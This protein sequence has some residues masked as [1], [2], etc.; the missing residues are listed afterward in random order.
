[1]RGIQSP[2]Y[3]DF[4]AS[5]VAVGPTQLPIQWVPG[6]ISPGIKRQGR[7]ADRSPPSST[8][9]KNG[10]AIPPLPHVL[11]ALCLINKAQGQLCLYI[12]S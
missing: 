12:T 8:Q 4:V 6:A 1:M 3:C 5:R 9:D 10:G 11:M 2:I 7:E